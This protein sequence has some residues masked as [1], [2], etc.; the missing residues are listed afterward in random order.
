MSKKFGQFLPL[1]L[2][3]QDNHSNALQVV[4]FLKS[5]MDANQQPT[6]NQSS[7][8]MNAGMPQ[9]MQQNMMM[10]PNQGMPMGGQGRPAPPGGFQQ[11]QQQF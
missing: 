5:T 4:N 11:Q 2:R 1:A 8:Q 6:P 10:Q 9:Q 3:R 7:Q